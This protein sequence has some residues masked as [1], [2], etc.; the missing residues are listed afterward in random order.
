MTEATATATAERSPTSTATPTPTATVA[1]TAGSAATDRAALVALYSAT[2][3]PN[4]AN[5]TNW[6]SNV[7]VGEWFGVTTDASGRVIALELNENGLRVSIPAELGSL[8]TLE[9]LDLSR[10]ELTGPIPAELGSLIAL[11]ELRLSANEL[12]GAIPAELGALANLREL[13][14]YGNN[15]HGPIP[16]ELGRIA[17]LGFLTLDRNQLTGCIPEGLRGGPRGDLGELGLPFCGAAERAASDRAALVALYWAANGAI[18]R[19]STNWLSDEPISEWYGVVT[20]KVG[21]VAELN[22]EGNELLGSIPAELG[23]LTGLTRLNLDGN[24][25]FGADPA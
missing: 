11:R 20:D 23:D 5:S 1:P 22:L 18:W 16:A 24:S 25:L 19:N 8:K 7:P 17:N 15:L 21:R 9:T 4:W 3:G 12:S 10:N 13:S 2:D 6:L 14:L